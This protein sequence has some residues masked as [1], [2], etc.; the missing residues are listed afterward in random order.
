MLSC[1]PTEC[2]QPTKKDQHCHLKE[3]GSMAASIDGL[4]SLTVPTVPLE[5][6]EGMAANSYSLRILT[7][8]T[9]P[10]EEDECM[11]LSSHAF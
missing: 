10:L 8:P 11:A 9:L 6:D 2:G 4:G 7:V 3:D 5:D 1:G